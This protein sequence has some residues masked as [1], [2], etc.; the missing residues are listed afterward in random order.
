MNPKYRYV[1]TKGGRK[2]QCPLCRKLR[3]V[4]YFDTDTGQLLPEQY[5][6]CDRE[7]NC[8][9]LLDPY[10]D[11]FVSS[12]DKCQEI[13]NK[14][15]IKPIKKEP[16]NLMLPSLIPLNHL[17]ESMQPSKPN[18]FIIWLKS[19]FDAENINK[20][21]SLYKIGSSCH[22]NGAT[23]FWQIDKSGWIRT[24]KIMLYDKLTGKRIKE[25]FNHINWIH[26]TLKIPEFNLK[27]CFFGEH[28]LRI[29]PS[30]I[31][32][33]VESEKTAIIAS[34]YFPRF[35]WMATGGKNGSK[36][37]K[38]EVF[39]IVKDRNIILFPDLRCFEDWE[40]KA[41][42]LQKEFTGTSIKTSD[43]LERNATEN[44]KNQGYD[45][46]DYIQICDINSLK[47]NQV[48]IK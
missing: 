9:Y 40:R 7:H 10:K 21:A 2:Y 12:T 18:N 36:W 13:G 42:A 30:K 3:F 5:G 20:I 39:E 14:H 25:P 24:G 35:I 27:Q 32:A 33:L 17:H 47:S 29:Q 8:G 11:G 1:F 22:W 38:P 28:L 43:F 26:S 44:D 45:L 31:I 16:P 46:A 6:R 19:R 37:Y 4:R 48:N 41:K 15:Y 34:L 23:V